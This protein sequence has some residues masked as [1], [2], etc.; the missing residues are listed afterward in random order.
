MGGCNSNY[1][2]EKEYIKVHYFPSDPDQKQRWINALVNILL[3]E[4]TQDI[5]LCIR[6][7]SSNYRTYSEKGH[8]FLLILHP[9]F[10][11]PVILHPRLAVHHQK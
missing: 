6:Y 4:Q 7:W 8:N 10:L 9:F 1:D 2:T 3:K 5:V 11:Y